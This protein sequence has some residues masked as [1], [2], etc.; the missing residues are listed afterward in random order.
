MC[1]YMRGWVRIAN[2]N[3]KYGGVPV[4]LS[5][6][7][8]RQWSTVTFKNCPM[9]FTWHHAAIHSA[10]PM[11]WAGFDPISRR[12]QCPKKE[13]T[14][15]T[16]YLL[17]GSVQYRQVSL[18]PSSFRACCLAFAGCCSAACAIATAKAHTA[19]RA[20]APFIP[21]LWTLAESAPRKLTGVPGVRFLGFKYL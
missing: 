11:P 10:S 7:L 18:T 2:A 17:P 6:P 13:A 1:M 15:P 20:K 5:S 9:T 12:R 8:P 16:R 3:V 14:S 19:S 4:P 21:Q